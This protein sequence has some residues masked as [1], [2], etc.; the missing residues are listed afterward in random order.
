M[1]SKGLYLFPFRPIQEFHLIH[2]SSPRHCLREPTTVSPVSPHALITFMVPQTGT[3]PP[4]YLKSRRHRGHRSHHPLLIPG[5]AP[6][7]RCGWIGCGI[8][9]D[10]NQQAISHHVN[11]VHK[12]GSQ[13][14]ICEWEEPGGGICGASM[15][16][17]NLRKH[18]L[19]IHT[20]LMIAWCEWCGGA[21]RRDV[22]PRHKKFCERRKSRY[23][24]I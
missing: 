16:P 17:N 19:D 14:M 13:E 15:Q 8:R 9:L 3:T 1:M 22:M 21:Q 4:I 23:I 5:D 20:T 2:L 24:L 11:A 10:Y 6:Q 7:I 12:R 18:T